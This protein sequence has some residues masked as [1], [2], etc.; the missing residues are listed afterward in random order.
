LKKP[1]FEIATIISKDFMSSEELKSLLHSTKANVEASDTPDFFE[2]FRNKLGDPVEIYNLDYKVIT[3]FK[4]SIIINSVENN[5]DDLENNG[6]IRIELVTNFDSDSVGHLFIEYLNRDPYVKRIRSSKIDYFEERLKALGKEINKLDTLIDHH[7]LGKKEASGSRSESGGTHIAFNEGAAFDL[8]EHK[9]ILIREKEEVS[10]K[11]KF[12]SSS[13]IYAI[14]EPHNPQEINQ[15]K[16]FRI[17]TI[18]KAL[19][20]SILIVELVYFVRRRSKTLKK[21]R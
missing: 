3:S 13:E 9:D 1:K 11:L 8:V 21:N 17:T 20:L 5:I 15:L 16:V 10:N 7:L 6:P 2:L 18:F 4:D 19:L 12:M 14:G